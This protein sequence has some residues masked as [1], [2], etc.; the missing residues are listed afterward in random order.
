MTKAML[1]KPRSDTARLSFIRSSLETALID[2][3]SGKQ[4]IFENTFN[5]IR[6]I[7]PLFEERLLQLQEAKEIRKIKNETKIRELKK[8]EY[9]VRDGM[10]SVK[11]KYLRLSMPRNLLEA[12]GLSKKGTLPKQK[13]IKDWLRFA[14]LFLAGAQQ[15]KENAELYP[16]IEPHLPIIKQNMETA[17]KAEAEAKTATISYTRKKENI[18]ETRKKVTTLIGDIM[19]ELRLNLRKMDKP[20]QRRIKKAYGFVYDV[21]ENEVEKEIEKEEEDETGQANE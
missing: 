11:R 7:I 20:S 12:Y 16:F 6:E 18:I 5:T 8:L 3:D 13:N 17:E 10:I 9:S 21:K 1:I 19:A 14:R 15:N 2:R 4:Y